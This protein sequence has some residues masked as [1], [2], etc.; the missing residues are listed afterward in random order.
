M[1]K[2]SDREPQENSKLLAV[3]V[4]E[5]DEAREVYELAQQLAHA[6]PLG[7]FED[8]I[9]AT[10][11]TGMINFRGSPHPV[12]NFA[13]Y[14]PGVLFPIDSVQ[15]LVTLLYEA[16]RMA[17]AWV[18]YSEND[19]NHAKR[20]LRRMGILGLRQGV[21]GRGGRA[22]GSQRT[23]PSVGVAEKPQTTEGKS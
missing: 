20:R 16:V 1:P 22:G 13:A 9:K 23:R 19:P 3:V 10:G 12:Q 14:V 11:V 8:L 21:L 2:H 6:L 15:K 5:V 4:E 7:S 18:K 17:P